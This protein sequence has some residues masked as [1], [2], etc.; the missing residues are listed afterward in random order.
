MRSQSPYPHH[1][2]LPP[3]FVATLSQPSPL[4]PSP[5]P[6]HCPPPLG[7]GRGRTSACSSSRAAA[8]K[9]AMRH[10]STTS[11][12][13]S[14]P[15]TSPV[16]ALP[17]SVT[18]TAVS[19]SPLATQPNALLPISQKMLRRA[20]HFSD[21]HPSLREWIR[22]GSKLAS[23]V[24]AKG[25]ASP[26]CLVPNPFLLGRAARVSLSSTASLHSLLLASKVT[27]CS[28]NRPMPC[29]GSTVN[30]PT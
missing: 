17:H 5:A 12:S 30:L 9:I 2:L 26:S 25:V 10:S 15:T 13:Q 29:C 7:R 4:T 14:S 8:C 11:H 19:V 6:S 22:V 21:Q 16:T 18:T 3:P 20:S 28:S 1:H 24:T 27:P 23:S